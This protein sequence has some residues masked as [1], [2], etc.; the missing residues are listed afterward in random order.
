MSV[1]MCL[2]LGLGV[3]QGRFNYGINSARR[4]RQRN[5]DVDLV[6]VACVA[7]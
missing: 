5:D 4:H 7:M 2:R 3:V 6:S 1:T